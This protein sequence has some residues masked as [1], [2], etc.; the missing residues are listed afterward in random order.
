MIVQE[1]NTIKGLTVA[2]NMFLGIEDE[3]TKHGVRNIKMMNTLARERLDAIGLKDINEKDD[4]IYYSM[5][6][7]KLIELVKA[8][9]VKPK[10]LMIDET[11]TALSQTGSDELYKLIRDTKERGDS[12][13]LISHDLQEVLTLCDRIIVMDDGTVNGFGTHDELLKTNEIYREV[14]ESQTKGG[15]ADE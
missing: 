11:S 3:F 12:V 14:Y 8:A 10:L 1:A 7:R 2:E 5:E 6:Q 15:G 4:V 9:T 13:L